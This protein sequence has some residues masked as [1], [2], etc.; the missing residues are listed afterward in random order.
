MVVL[1]ARCGFLLAGVFLSG[2]A[3]A[4]AVPDSGAS[5][6]VTMLLRL[7][8][9]LGAVIAAII[10]LTWFL[11]RIG[12]ITQNTGSQLKILGGLAVGQR[13]R[14]VLLQVGDQQLLIGVAPGRV[15]TLHVLEQ[16]LDGLREPD[17]S[18]QVRDGSFA[19]RLRRV[20]Q[21]QRE[22]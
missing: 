18:R 2:P 20:M 16:P 19:D 15:Q 1:A 10:G 9:G 17:G 7:I 13:E 21:Q 6:D 8:V 11:R 14:V 3:L 5:V 12:G 4:A 22:K